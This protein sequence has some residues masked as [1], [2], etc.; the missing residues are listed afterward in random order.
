MS[1]DKNAPL[2]YRTL[3]RLVFLAAGIAVVLW[4]VHSLQEVLLIFFLALVIGIVLNAPVV[5]LEARKIP[6]LI[7]AFIVLII[8]GGMGVGI[9]YLVIPRLVSQVASLITMQLNPV[10]MLFVTL[11]MTYMFGIVGAI[12]SAPLAGFLKSYWD[13]F[14][15]SRQTDEPHIEE[16]VDVMVRRETVEAGMPA[17]PLSQPGPKQQEKAEAAIKQEPKTEETPSPTTLPGAGK[18]PP[19]KK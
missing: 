11:A 8:V 7:A 3:S 14:Y 6:R 12:V 2:N 17:G 5:W 1:M 10:Y 9:A 18:R 15:L 13:E 19:S 16:K 4:I